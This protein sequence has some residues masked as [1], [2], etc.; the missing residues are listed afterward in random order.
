MKQQKDY[1]RN[2][3]MA[4]LRNLKGALGEK[5]SFEKFIAASVESIMMLER[6][7]YLREL[8]DTQEQR[9]DKGNGFYRRLFE[10]FKT[11]NSQIQVPRTLCIISITCHPH[12]R[13]LSRFHR[14]WCSHRE[15]GCLLQCRQARSPLGHWSLWVFQASL[16][17]LSQL[18]P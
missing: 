18:A 1:Q 2:V 15:A 9:G 16:R 8:T 3:I 6:E 11:H 13:L 4:S 10:S 7:E 14:W 12:S 17:E 5:V